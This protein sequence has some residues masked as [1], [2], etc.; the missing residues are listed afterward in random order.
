M[1]LD[2]PISAKNI[3]TS[4]HPVESVMNASIPTI[5]SVK[6]ADALT[7]G[8]LKLT[9]W[10]VLFEVLTYKLYALWERAVL[11]VFLR[12]PL[13]NATLTF[14]LHC[15]ETQSGTNTEVSPCCLDGLLSISVNKLLWVF[16]SSMLT[17]VVS[18]PVLSFVWLHKN[19]QFK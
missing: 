15:R 5:N 11:P 10:S 3:P 7:T 6:L 2:C 12:K 13:E 18:F 16:I 9:G 8:T 14:T 1:T 17:F 19:K 4:S